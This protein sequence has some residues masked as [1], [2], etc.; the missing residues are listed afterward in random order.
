MAVSV[1][2]RLLDAQEGGLLRS[3]GRNVSEHRSAPSGSVE[4]GRILMKILVYGLL[5]VVAV[6][7]WQVYV[8]RSEHSDLASQQKAV[9]DEALAGQEAFNMRTLKELERLE[10]ELGGHTPSRRR[11]LDSWE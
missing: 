1:S 6:L 7:A 3:Q 9:T 8:L 10:L 5:L 11:S 2:R 4:R